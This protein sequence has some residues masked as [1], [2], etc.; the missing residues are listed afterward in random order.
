MTGYLLFCAILDRGGLAGMSEISDKALTDDEFALL[1]R[2]LRR[3]V[4]TDMDQFENWK[5][6]GPHSTVYVEIGF[7]PG[8]QGTEDSYA[9]LSHLLN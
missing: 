4:A 7:N 9:D 2:L 6:E 3:Y 1:V 8:R 5:F